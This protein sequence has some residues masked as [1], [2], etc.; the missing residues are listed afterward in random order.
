[1]N[2]FHLEPKTKQWEVVDVELGQV[3]HCDTQ[4][5]RDAFQNAIE[6]IGHRV[7]VRE[8]MA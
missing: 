8:V 3:F 4:D 2:G 7:L 6:L 5:G 1:M